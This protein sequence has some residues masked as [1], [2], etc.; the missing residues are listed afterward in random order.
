MEIV[1]ENSPEERA[2]NIE[3]IEKTNTPYSSYYSSWYAN[4]AGV[5]TNI[6]YVLSKRTIDEAIMRLKDPHG[7]PEGINAVIFIA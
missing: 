1:D 3:L 5:T 6:H 4:Q 2:T 7:F